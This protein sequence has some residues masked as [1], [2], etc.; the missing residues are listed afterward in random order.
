MIFV[1]IKLNISMIILLYTTALVLD[2]PTSIEL[3]F[4]W[5][6]KYDDTEDTINAKKIVFKIAYVT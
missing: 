1:K 4:A 6:P 5:K 3:P 2:F